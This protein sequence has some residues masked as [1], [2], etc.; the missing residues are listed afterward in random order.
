MADPAPNPEPEPIKKL[1]EDARKLQEH[2]DR[3]IRDTDELLERIKQISIEP[4]KRPPKQDR[5]GADDLP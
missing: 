5:G 3:L 1:R 4:E 2:L